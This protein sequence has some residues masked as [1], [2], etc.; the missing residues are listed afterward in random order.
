MSPFHLLP[1]HI[2]TRDIFCLVMMAV[3]C[4]KLLWFTFLYTYYLSLVHTILLVYNSL[5]TASLLLN[6]AHI[7]SILYI[8]PYF[9][10]FFWKYKSGHVTFL[11]KSFHGSQSLIP[12]KSHIELSMTSPWS[13]LHA[14]TFHQTIMVGNFVQFSKIAMLSCLWACVH[15]V[16]TAWSVLSNYFLP[17]SYLSFISW[18]RH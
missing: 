5:W 2:P 13:P 16:Q 1:Q 4:N 15:T 8:A 12:Q 18:C 6:L 14:L 7:Q 17:N 9:F 10:F 11:I 3:Q